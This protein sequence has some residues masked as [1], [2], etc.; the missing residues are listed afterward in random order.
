MATIVAALRRLANA[1]ANE[2]RKRVAPLLA[3]HVRNSDPARR[4][5]AVQA[6]AV[7][8]TPEAAKM[9]R[10]FIDDADKATRL[11]VIRSLGELKDTQS[12]D[13]IAARMTTPADRVAAVK[14]LKEMGDQ[15]EIA[16]LKLLESD[17]M[18]I[19]VSAIDV[20]A[21]VGGLSAREALE[22]TIESDTE[23]FVRARAQ[24]ALRELQSRPPVDAG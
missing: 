13:L 5:L 6:L 11:A 15:A 12:I 17:D 18:W 22:A 8:A 4:A 3:D 20:L 7:W 10:R 16:G 14:A 19:R 23:E 2:E 21:K 1:A 9:L 24:S